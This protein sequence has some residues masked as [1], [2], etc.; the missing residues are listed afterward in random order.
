MDGQKMGKYENEAL[1]ELK[2]KEGLSPDFDGTDLFARIDILTR[3]STV[4]LAAEE[5]YGYLP[6]DVVRDK[7]GNASALAIAELFAFLKSTQSTPF[8]FLNSLYAKY[9][10]HFEKTENLYFEGAEGSATITKLAQSYRK[11][12]LS[13]VDDI[14]VTKTKDFLES[15]YIDEDEDPCQQN[16]LQMN[17]EN[18]FSIAI[19]PSGTEPKIKYIFSVRGQK[20]INL[21]D[22]KK[23]VREK[24]RTW[25]PLVYMQKAG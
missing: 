11:N 15:G 13:A 7:D 18:G 17:L 8:D 21:N 14:A 6:L 19:R 12:P 23:E 24:S 2:E 4:V 10:Y 5:S 20:S 9:G 22:S 1:I 25:L 3:Y 16:F